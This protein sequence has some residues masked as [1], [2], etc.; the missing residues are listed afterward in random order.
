VRKKKELRRL[1]ELRAKSAE[2]RGS[3]EVGK[4]KESKRPK[5]PLSHLLKLHPRT[6]LPG[7]RGGQG[8]RAKIIHTNC[9]WLPW[10]RIR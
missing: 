8:V 9:T 5:F 1:R 10:R 3:R 6:T 2:E 7:G 4:K